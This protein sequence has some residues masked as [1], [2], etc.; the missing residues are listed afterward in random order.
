MDIISNNANNIILAFTF[1]FMGI[2]S[3]LYLLYEKKLTYDNCNE[4]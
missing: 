1:L 4:I 3:F 2:F